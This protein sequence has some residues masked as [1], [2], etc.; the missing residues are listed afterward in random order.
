[1]STD[2]RERPEKET[3]RVEAFSDGVFAIAI[4]LLVLDLKVPRGSGNRLGTE[5]VESW[6][7]YGAFLVSFATIGIMWLN[8]H[9]LFT[10]IH[11]VDHALLVLNGLLLLTITVVPY[12]TSLLAAHLGSEGARLAALVYCG[13]F[14]VIAIAFNV[15]W[16]YV[17]S[18]ERRPPLLR[19]ALDSPQVR[20]ITAAYRFGPL[21][22][23]VA[24]LLSYWHALAG[25]AVCGALA[26]FFA[27]P[28]RAA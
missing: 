11:R 9:R 16:R 19:H 14:I 21:W 6:P 10:L 4:T 20:E 1:M 2:P 26:L 8:H 3:A 24:F 18:P 15:F 17:S 12:P 7:S 28:P 13:W 23:V 25:I 22:Y 27:L 5:L